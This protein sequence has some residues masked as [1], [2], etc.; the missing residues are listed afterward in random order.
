MSSWEL[1]ALEGLPLLNPQRA[2]QGKWFSNFGRCGEP[3]D[4]AKT[5]AAGLPQDR[6]TPDKYHPLWAFTASEGSSHARALVLSKS[7]R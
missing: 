3:V 6:I 1:K 2:S 4:S 7:V 5:S